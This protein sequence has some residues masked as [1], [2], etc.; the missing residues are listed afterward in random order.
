[1]KWPGVWGKGKSGQVK[2]RRKKKK[3]K[4]KKEKNQ[5]QI[6]GKIGGTSQGEPTK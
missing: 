3:G 5:E 1:M 2:E 6:M 4:R